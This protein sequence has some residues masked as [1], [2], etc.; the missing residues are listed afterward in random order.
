MRPALPYIRHCLLILPLLLALA[1]GQVGKELNL[2]LEQSVYLQEKTG[3][4]ESSSQPYL[5]FPHLQE[6]PFYDGKE[7][8]KRI[9]KAEMEQDLLALD[10]LL[11]NFIGRWGIQN[12]NQ[13]VDYLWKAGQ[14]KELLGDTVASALYYEIGLKNQRPYKPQVK[15]HFDSLK[16]QKNVE[17]VDLQFYYKILE[18][19]R[20]IDPLIPPKGVMLNMGPKINSERPDYAPFMHPSDSVL[21]FTSRRDEEIVI[22]DINERKNEDLYFVEKGFIDGTWSYAERFSGVINSQYNEGSATLSP[23][24]RTLY[25]TRC[26]EPNGY[27]SCDIYIADFLGGD[28]TNIRNIGPNVNSSAWD[29]HPNITPDGKALYFTSNRKGGFGKSD[30]YVT[31]RLEDGT[32]TTA[33]NLG[34]TINT[35]EDEV[36]PFFHQVNQ[37]LYFSSTGH[38]KNLGGY[39]IYKSRWL[40]DHWESPKNVGP[41]VNSNANEYY[42]SIDGKGTR[43]FYASA[44]KDQHKAEYKQNFDLYSFPMPME[45]RPDAIVTLRGYLIDSITG[46][47]VTGIVLVIDRDQGIEVA[48]KHINKY[49]YFEFD[50]INNHKYDIYIQGENFLT[51]KEDVT[52]SGDTTFV[53]ITKSFDAGKAM[54]FENLEF[55]DDSYELNDRIEPKLNY[56]ISFLK[57]YPMFR[58]EV[59]GHTDSDGEAKYNLELSRKR[60]AMIRKYLIKA[61]G[62]GDDWILA[63]GYG[64]TRPL[65][66]NDTE[67]HKKLNRRVEFALYLDPKYDMNT[68]VLPTSEEFD[69]DDMGDEEFDPEFMKETD[70]E[71]NTDEELDDYEWMADPEEDAELLQEFDDF[72]KDVSTNP[73]LDDD[74]EDEEEEDEE[75][76]DGD[77][78]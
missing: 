62:F 7:Y 26:D 17:W 23:D 45:A 73:P 28:W 39:D 16:A 22:D 8:M 75:D 6:Y 32:W 14:V 76:L 12:F 9:E 3:E 13:D 48:P 56:L 1:H 54:V 61:G 34:P 42:F 65:V 5:V 2:K 59:K 50:L 40:D 33:E 66:A 70:W 55:D 36:T 11:S 64:E 43:L 4:N 29:S 37:T 53:E 68:G 47:P 78:E 60:S 27:G 21:I 38:L 46:H 31:R 72:G 35:I 41:L 25:F 74:L 44:K 67:E 30:L 77:Q 71:W 58:L 69:F 24:G 15:I 20:K 63:E 57:K 51:I 10:T 18:A 52:L 19:R 49:G